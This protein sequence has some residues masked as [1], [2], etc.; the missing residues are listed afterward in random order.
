VKRLALLTLLLLPA[1]ASAQPITMKET[2]H[3]VKAF[4]RWQW[5]PYRTDI[6]RG[7]YCVRLSRIGAKCRLR[8]VPHTPTF[9]LGSDVTAEFVPCTSRLRLRIGKP[10][11]ESE[12]KV[13]RLVVRS[14]QCV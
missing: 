7:P 1:S 3:A 6:I 5:E 12:L 8:L 14:V 11:W 10:V 4:T 9:D 2:R 13:G